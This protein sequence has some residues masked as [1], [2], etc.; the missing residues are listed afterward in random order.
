MNFSNEWKD[1]AARETL[2]VT[3]LLVGTLTAQ[4]LLLRLEMGYGILYPALFLY[5]LRICYGA[6]RYAHS[7]PHLHHDFHRILTVLGT[8]LTMLGAFWMFSGV[9]VPK[10]LPVSALAGG[11]ALIVWAQRLFSKSPRHGSAAV[12]SQSPAT[13]RPPES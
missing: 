4:P 12:N 8:L 3:A 6:V 5:W 9:A 13:E 1:T 10:W 7:R 11:V 2:I